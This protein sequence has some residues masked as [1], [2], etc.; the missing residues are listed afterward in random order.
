MCCF[1]QLL[2]MNLVPDQRFP[3]TGWSFKLDWQ[4][5]VDTGLSKD[6]CIYVFSSAGGKPACICILSDSLLN[7][8]RV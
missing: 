6:V 5:R 7:I 3:A 8:Y 1:V 2:C 4:L